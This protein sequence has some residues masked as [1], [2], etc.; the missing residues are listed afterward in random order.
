MPDK[1][2]TTVDKPRGKYTI[3]DIARLADVSR[4]TVSLAIND[5]PKINPETKAKV[6]KVIEEVGYR[7]NQAARNLVSRESGTILVVAPQIDHVFS[8]WY[9]SEGLSGIL[10]ATTRLGRHLMVQLATEDF[11]KSSRALKLWREHIV[12]GIL[13][14]GALRSDEYIQEI[15]AAGCP[16]VLVNSMADGV[17][18]VTAANQ[19][20]AIRVI[21]HLHSL[22]HRRIGHIRGSQDVTYASERLAGYLKAVTD[23]GLDPDPSLIVQGWFGQRSGAEAMTRLMGLSPR[24]TAIF[25]AN[26]LMAIGAI[27]AANS[28]G[29]RVPGDVAIVGADDVQLARYVRPTLT[30]IRQSMYTLGEA[31]VEHLVAH[32]EGRKVYTPNVQVGM[33]LVIRES[34]GARTMGVS[35]E[36]AH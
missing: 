17:S 3:R 24:P 34:C 19:A 26:D 30:T 2:K 6:L 29:L 10:D 31:A 18:S 36:S 11:K 27:E 28:M 32:I 23:L 33:R 9:F 21:Q 13:A 22:G 16:V 14:I 5:S 1:S 15:A 12:D 35:E 25:A 20:G 4:S 8:D 7:P